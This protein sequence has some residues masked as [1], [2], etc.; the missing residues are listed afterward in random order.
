LVCTRTACCNDSDG[1]CRQVNAPATCD[2]GETSLGFGTNC[3]PNCCE[4]KVSPY[5][6]GYDFCSAAGAAAP[7]IN[8]PA[9]GDPAVTVTF[10]GNN[11][12]ATFGDADP[13]AEGTCQLGIF[14]Q[15]GGTDDRG[16][17][18]A[19][20]TDACANIRIDFCCTEERAGEPKRPWNT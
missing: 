13:N 4:A 2:V 11:A 3:D 19:F 7:V 10:S 20:S 18:H 8:V 17:W 16:W 15:G 14:T 1:T 5:I 12:S 6:N 9:P